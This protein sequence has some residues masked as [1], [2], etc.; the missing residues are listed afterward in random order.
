MF[1]RP[2]EFANL[3]RAATRFGPSPWDTPRYSEPVKFHISD[4]VS[5]GLD[6]MDYR[7]EEAK[8]VSK[9][10]DKPTLPDR[11][12]DRKMALNKC[13]VEM[14]EIND[15]HKESIESKFG[16]V[17][18]DCVTELYNGAMSTIT[19]N[20]KLG[21]KDELRIAQVVNDA[22]ELAAM[23]AI[24]MVWLTEQLGIN[25]PQNYGEIV[26]DAFKIVGKRVD[27]HIEDMWADI[28]T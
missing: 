12:A 8:V 24:E 1:Y 28:N 2:E 20:V 10:G 5:K 6:E 9:S 18:Q 4:P 21:V 19:D 17:V 3:V 22:I 11:Y 23:T 14:V 25:E 16:A 26:E 13:F 27:Q 15:S 7:R